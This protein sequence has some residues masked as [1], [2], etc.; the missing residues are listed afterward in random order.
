[1]GNN[2][3]KYQGDSLPVHGLSVRDA[4][5]YCNKKSEAEGLRGF[6]NI[7]ENTVLLKSNGNGYRLP[8]ETE[9]TLASKKTKEIIN[10]HNYPQVEREYDFKPHIIGEVPDRRREL[11]DVYG[12]VSELCVRSNGEIW[13]KGGSYTIALDS[14]NNEHDGLKAA[15]N[16]S[17]TQK[18][19]V[20]FGLRLVFIP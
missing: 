18:L 8:T 14:E 5:I 3:S 17:S 6:Y 11:F 1:M 12:N 13:G 10:E 9:W 15:E 20:D 2:P 7:S 4:V 19:N 16:I